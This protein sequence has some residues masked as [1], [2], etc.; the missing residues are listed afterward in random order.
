[1]VGF[2]A[3]VAPL[4]LLP[5]VQA[6]RVT[7]AQRAVAPPAAGTSG[8]GSSGSGSSQSDQM[9]ALWDQ[10]RAATQAGTVLASQIG[11]GKAQ[12]AQLQGQISALNRQLASAQAQEAVDAAQL[13]ATDQ[14][15][16]SLEASIV[17]TT[18]QATG[19]QSQVVQRSIE[20]YKEGPASY[21]AMLV[22]ATSFRDFLTRLSFVSGV[23]ASDRAKL[24]ALLTTN[25]QLSSQRQEAVQ[26]R[27]SVAEAKAA[28][29]LDAADIAQL[30]AGVAQANQALA[31][32][33][34]AQQDQ[35]K[36]IEAQKATY[37]KDMATLTAESSSITTFVRSKQIS[38]SYTWAG[39][40]VLWPVHGPITSPFGPRINP[41]FGN[42]EF[43]TG[44]DIGAAT[45][46]PVLAAEAGT[47][48][49]SGV[50]Q[51]YGNVIILD[52]GGALA[53]LYAHQSAL[54]VSVGQKVAKGQQ[55]GK[56]GCTGLCTGPHLHFETR[57][58]GSP[59]QPLSFLP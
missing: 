18:A 45:G 44:I 28:L 19:A 39:K 16:A 41:V 36:G 35:L 15:L 25:T 26:R 58:G 13:Q 3:F 55:I 12:Q 43:H 54:L 17:T 27:A 38:Q 57:V 59:V 46:V 29:A 42:S 24:T 50:M 32:T 20:L 49:Y 10:F 22:S 40:L 31:V 33:V 5:S 7:A 52:H 4:V 48:I 47:V 9:A 53:T 2:A 8:S 51:G 34:A 37:L 14:Q 56:V 11:A 6:A 21:L 1:M 30:R 23:I